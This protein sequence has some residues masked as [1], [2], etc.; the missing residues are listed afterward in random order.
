MSEIVLAG[1][2]FWGLQ[3][4]FSK[5]NGVLHTQVGYSG[6]HKKNPS[7]EE[8]CTDTTGYAESILIQYDNNIITLSE[9]L[10]IFF[11]CHNPTTLN[12][13][14]TDWGT[15]YRSAIFYSTPEEQK[16]IKKK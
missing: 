16:I 3:A 9:I 10:D 13:Q 6:G 4:I 15:Q 1:G 11:M 14:G 7:Y 5:V 8:V 12:R 2:C